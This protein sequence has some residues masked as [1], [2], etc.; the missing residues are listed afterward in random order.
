MNIEK[1]K[2]ESIKI[3]GANPEEIN[4]KETNPN[5]S[6][7][8]E[9]NP[10]ET[11]PDNIKSAKRNDIIS[12][13]KRSTYYTDKKV[14][15]ARKNANKYD[16][17]KTL[18]D[19]A[20][21]EA[22]KYLM[23]DEY[24][25]SIVT[26]P[27]I[28]RAFVHIRR[29]K[30]IDLGCP[31]CG[32]NINKY[33][34]YPWKVDHL[35]RPWKL[36]CPECKIIFPTNDFGA[37][38][39]SGLDN[40]GIFRKE[41]AD[42]NLL[43]N[44][45]YPEK[46]EAWG[47]DDGFG[48]KNGDNTWTFI[49]YYNHWAIWYNGFVQ[50]ALRTF[51]NAYI[52]TGDI[53]YARAGI[54]LLDRI[55][56]FYP[57]M[58]ITDF[59]WEDGFD[60]GTP[61]MNTAQG[62]ILHDIWE[63]VLITEFVSA[64]D[65]FFPILNDSVPGNVVQFLSKKAE[66][67][68]I[69]S[70]K[71]SV[72]GIRKNIEDNLIRQVLPAFKN[73]Q[74]RGNFGM[75]QATLAMAAVVLDDKSTTQEMIDYNYRTGKLVKITGSEYPYGRKFIVTGGNVLATLIDDVDR[76][77]F[78]NE[79]APGYNS[80]WLKQLKLVADVL[81]GYDRY[82]D[83]DLYKNAKFRKMFTAHYNLIMIGKYVP[84]IGDS[85]ACGQPGMIMSTDV[86]VKAFEKYGEPIFAQLA[87]MF[88]KNSVAG[89]HGDIFSENPDKISQ[90]I[91]NVIERYG[92]INLESINLTGFGLSVLR[93]GKDHGQRDVWMYYGRNTGHGHRDTL[94]IG[95]H[96][97]GLNLAPD[98]GYPEDTGINPDR[99]EWTSNTI[100][101]N[102][103]VVDRTRQSMQVVGIPKHFDK[104]E[105][106]KL[107][108]IEAPLVYPQTN[109]YRRTTAMIKVNDEHSYIVDFF[110]V[111]G[112]NEHHFS[113]HSNEAVV[114]TEGLNLVKQPTGT[115]AGQDVHFK[116]K[117]EDDSMPGAKYTGPGFHYLYNV[118]KDNNP[119][120]I[121]S[122]DWQQVKDMDVHL[123]LTMIGDVESVALVD[124]DPPQNKP[125]NPRR[126]K[127]MIAARKGNDINSIFT[128]VI[129]PFRKE[130]YIKLINPVEVKLGDS[131]I[132]EDV[133]AVKV[134]LDNGRIDYIIIALNSDATYS[135]DNKFQFRGFFGVYS[136][137]AGK[138]VTL[139]IN[140]GELIGEMTQVKKHLSGTVIDFTKE[141]KV[142]NKITVQFTDQ[143]NNFKATD[144]NINS[145]FTDQNIN[146]ED[147]QGRYIYIDNDND[148]KRNAVYRIKGVKA[149]DKNIVTL[150]IGD[151][152]PIKCWKNPQDFSE[153]YLFDFTEGANFVIPLSGSIRREK[154]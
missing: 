19:V 63:T 18:R 115:Y 89:I 147:L 47:I 72:G 149:F 82:S 142:D 52:Y 140:D 126:L 116:Q 132:T 30:A 66:Q 33:G 84:S 59:S 91:A 114:T 151:L 14:A 137:E 69:D 93:D 130:R 9:I 99:F 97:Y 85:G 11:N 32:Q 133:R 146:I 143:N 44:E 101:H 87:Y 41:K 28:P 83:V 49:A 26:S 139:Y 58:D 27:T 25:W 38:Y 68:D 154:A 125:G 20:V 113:F 134:T 56:D 37:Y 119:S 62:R 123:R 29:P 6:N 75:H 36:E 73:S 102:T 86:F 51:K 54:I 17:V 109:M 103:V 15:N 43:K 24:L 81:D 46:G 148:K 80:I 60:N 90:D 118:E 144:Q 79:A 120:N 21:A 138:Y 104:T 22:D 39:N 31:V 112:G 45:L 12:A 7:P 35:K 65:A 136:E 50:N 105:L 117:P 61:Y 64:Y 1:A 2:K 152:T 150:D 74:I 124:G 94:N 8:G 129:E 67:Y 16:W 98:L 77:G 111:K 107:M 42:K 110:H 4:S 128:S 53:K 13:K 96:A 40:K 100:S 3:G 92:S 5:E 108:D 76:D 106:V 145:T 10:K 153:G 23:D 135:I 88:N 141:L 78:G 95:I 71:H 70:Y 121:F 34:N 48:W 57:N 122:V 131:I 55:A 127:F